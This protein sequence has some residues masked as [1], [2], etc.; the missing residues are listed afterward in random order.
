MKVSDFLFVDDGAILTDSRERLIRLSNIVK[1]QFARIG[2][3]MHVGDPNDPEKKSKSVAMYFPAQ[4][5]DVTEDSLPQELQFDL[6]AGGNVHFV[7]SFRYL[8]SFIQQNLKDT[9]DIEFR[10][11]KAKGKMKQLSAV[12]NS[13]LLSLKLR[14]AIYKTHVQG[15]LL[16]GCEA[17]CLRC[18]D[19][20]ML[21]VFHLRCLRQLL[22]IN[23]YHVRE[24]HIK[25][26]TVLKETKCTSITDTIIIRQLN[27]INNLGQG[28]LD[29]IEKQLG[30]DFE[31]FHP[32]KLL[33]AWIGK[34]RPHSNW[35]TMRNT[36]KEALEEIYQGEDD[37]IHDGRFNTWGFDI[38]NEHLKK[39]IEGY[40]KDCLNDVLHPREE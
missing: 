7:R 39:R 19:K 18:S 14:T 25:N 26:T 6:T 30:S 20:K 22:G 37:E 17:W 12:L 2:L 29:C 34:K 32:S 13:N 23:M 35:K 10:I 31:S 15:T 28:Y 1:E 40:K 5:E 9:Y 16:Y 24:H 4:I 27:W 8:G 11:N 36:Y 3:L 21:E 33:F 38:E